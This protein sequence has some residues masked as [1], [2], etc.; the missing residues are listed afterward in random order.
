MIAIVDNS[1]YA[2]RFMRFDAPF[3]KEVIEQTIC[4]VFF[5]SDPK[6]RI[7]G[8]IVAFAEF[9]DWRAPGAI[10]EFCSVVWPDY[11]FYGQLPEDEFPKDAVSFMGS[12]LWEAAG[13]TSCR[14]IL[15]QEL[16]NEFNSEQ[17]QAF[18]NAWSPDRLREFAVDKQYLEILKRYP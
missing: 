6:G 1:D 13:Y 4:R 11:F 14:Y 15:K 2:I 10:E 3:T 17:K 9:L 16:W 8:Y 7:E 18:F 12:Y 5:G